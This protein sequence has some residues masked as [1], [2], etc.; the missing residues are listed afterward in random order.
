VD[1]VDTRGR[2]GDVM[3][4]A[5]F[6]FVIGFAIMVV[7]AVAG[8]L[9]MVVAVLGGLAGWG[10]ARFSAGRHSL[11]DWFERMSAGG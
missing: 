11:R 7:W 8:F 2:M 5:Q 10:I 6:G 1:I 9:V 3:T 4:R